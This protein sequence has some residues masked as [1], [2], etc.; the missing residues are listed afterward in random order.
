MLSLVLLLVG[1][2]WASEEPGGLLLRKGLVRWQLPLKEAR[3][4]IEENIRP[5]SQTLN[6]LA[7]QKQEE[8]GFR[9]EQEATPG[10]TRCIWACCV[11]LGVKD[12]VYFAT[13]WF[14][15]DRF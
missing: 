2:V 11:D 4:F 10:V 3:T 8:E 7:G 1:Q 15:N 13:L 5:K 9:C 6:L 14:Y 12:T